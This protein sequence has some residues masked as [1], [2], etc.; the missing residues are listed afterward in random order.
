MATQ[1]TRA[2]APGVSRAPM[3]IHYVKI[4]NF[5]GHQNT[6][7]SFD[8][9]HALVGENGIGKTSVLDAIRLACSPS[10][11]ASRLCEQDFNMADTGPIQIEVK[12]RN[13]FICKDR[14]GYSEHRVP[15]QSVVLSAKRRERATPGRAL[16][17]PF[18]TTSRCVPL[19]YGNRREIKKELL[20][21]G[22]EKE[23][24][25]DA[26]QAVTDR[27]E[28]GYRLTL[29]NGNT[30]QIPQDQLLLSNPLIGF[31]NVFMFDREREREARPG[32]TSVFTRIAKELNWRFRNGVV[33]ADLR[34][35]WEAFHK[36]VFDTVDKRFAGD[37]IGPVSELLV[38]AVGSRVAGLELSLLNVEEPFLKAFFALREG[39]NQVELEGVGSGISMLFSL[40]L[41]EHVSSMS[42]EDCI[43]LI[44]EPEMHLHPQLQRF[45]AGHLRRSTYQNIISTHSPAF[46]SFGSWK[47]I[48]RFHDRGTS[49]TRAG[50]AKKVGSQEVHQCLD[51]ICSYR[52]HETVFAD[53]DA[54]LLFAR[55][56]VL[57]E[58]PVEK[59][60]VPRLSKLL[61]KDT[62]GLSFISCN[63]KDKIKFYAVLCHA[64]DVPAFVLFD[65]DGEPDTQADNMA[66]LSAIDGMGRFAF[67]QSFE[68]CFGVGKNANHK[69]TKVLMAIDSFQDAAKLPAE[70]RS[71]L[72]AIDEWRESASRSAT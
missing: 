47:A 7:V 30:R 6:C 20:P 22:V 43:F 3:A 10:F 40:L 5:R 35:H 21:E 46:V 19:E 31:P 33:P 53:H 12:F 66:V 45:L 39:T 17:E 28:P 14:D 34:A 65:C 57:T 72:M 2:S 38:E 32:F 4:Q 27:E 54:E 16:S 60:G 52:Q 50:L 25:V 58:G 41:L 26:V 23:S 1:T 15:C 18:V 9:H 42:K 69:A 67:K 71:A 61:G 59:Y 44:D 8:H 36:T 49:P 24:L 29:K 11:V 70:V 68:S 62:S 48:T 51:E 64:Y 55:Q 63:S 56:V 37:L 13:L